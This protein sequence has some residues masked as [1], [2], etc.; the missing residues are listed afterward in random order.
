[1]FFSSSAKYEFGR[2]EI[3]SNQGEWEG[4]SGEIETARRVRHYLM[5]KRPWK[6]ETHGKKR[7]ACTK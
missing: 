6:V 7:I 5:Y 4:P 1:M 3:Q 2:V